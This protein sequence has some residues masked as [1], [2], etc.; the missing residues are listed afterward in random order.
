MLIDAGAA[1]AEGAAAAARARAAAAIGIT[2]QLIAGCDGPAPVSDFGIT[3]L[4]RRR[5]VLA[6]GRA[7]EVDWCAAAD[8][9]R[10]DHARDQIA[11]ASQRGAVA[12]D[13]FTA[14]ADELAQDM[15]VVE[16][17]R[18]GLPIRLAD[19]ALAAELARAHPRA[20]FV[21]SAPGDA[22]PADAAMDALAARPNVHLD[23]ATCGAVRGA[24]DAALQRFGPDRLLWGTAARLDVAL[25]QLRALDVI[26]P[27]EGVLDNI[28]WRNALRL[29]KR[30]GGEG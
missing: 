30:L 9:R 13:L 21:C 26:A 27:G 28:R 15:A 24:I 29:Y 5:R 11:R 8:A 4:N 25:A 12:V 14:G 7:G 20:A 18:R 6:R 23:L 10:P 22:L 16:A 1:L 19:A 3:S 2:R 17:S